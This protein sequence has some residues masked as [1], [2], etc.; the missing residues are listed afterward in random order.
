MQNPIRRARGA[1]FALAAA[2]TA[3]FLPASGQAS[4]LADPCGTGSNP[5]VCENS[6]PG[7]PMS[8]WFAG[9]SWGTSPASPPR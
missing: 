9:S 6:K 1:V 7:T 3:I 2:L 8:D 5:I 4:A